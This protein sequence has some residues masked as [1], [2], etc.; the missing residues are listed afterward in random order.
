M[1]F[2]AL[3][4]EEQLLGDV[5]HTAKHPLKRRWP[6]GRHQDP[7][8]LL[9]VGFLCLCGEQA[10]ANEIPHLPQGISQHL[11]ETG[12]VAYFVD[13]LLGG[14]GDDAAVE[15]L[16][17]DDGA[18]TLG[19]LGYSQDALAGVDIGQVADHRLRRRLG[20]GDGGRSHGPS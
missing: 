14:D 18:V 7:M 11:A 1:N 13:E 6:E 15:E 9:P 8:R 20:Y 4:V 12:F 3:S 19:E 2:R 16:D 10:V 17:T 5:V